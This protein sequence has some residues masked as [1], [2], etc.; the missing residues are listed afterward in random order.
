MYHLVLRAIFFRLYKVWLFPE[1]GCKTC[2]STLDSQQFEARIV[3]NPA[4]INRCNRW[5]CHYLSLGFL[6]TLVW[7]P[8]TPTWNC[9]CLILQDILRSLCQY[10]MFTLLIK[11]SRQDR[12]KIQSK[13]YFYMKHTVNTSVLSLDLRP[14]KRKSLY[15]EQH[16]Y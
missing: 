10:P 16:A 13:V 11:L 9:V 12:T 6:I 4:L 2:T 8:E 3:R 1:D 15:L 5:A 7:C 14:N